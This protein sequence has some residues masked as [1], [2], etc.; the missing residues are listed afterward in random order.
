[1]NLEHIRRT[2]TKHGMSRTRIYGL[3]RHMID[4]CTRNTHRSFH[5]YG[6]RGITVCERWLTSF[7][8]FYQDMGDCPKGM[9]L[10]RIDNE[11]GYAPENCRWASW[12]VQ[13]SNKRVCVY[14]EWNGQ[15]L[16]L[17]EWGKIL[18]IPYDVLRKRYRNGWNTEKIL[19]TPVDV[20]LSRNHPPLTHCKRGHLLDE[21]NTYLNFSRPMVQRVCRTCQTE[22]SRQS[23]ARHAV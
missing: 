2:Y 21:K 13:A 23:R 1:M 15:R 5:N 20:R 18:G 11:K 17:A 16:T 9:S 12:D 19:I 6:G 14:F 3:W 10:D 7:D 8:F 4:R 22:H